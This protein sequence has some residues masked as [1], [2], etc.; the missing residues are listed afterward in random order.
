MP[1]VLESSLSEA[2]VVMASISSR[3]SSGST[4]P[5]GKT[6]APP[7]FA[8]EARSTRKTSTPSFASLTNKTVA[9]GCG[10]V[11]S[12]LGS[13]ICVFAPCNGFFINRPYFSQIIID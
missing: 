13:A 8:L 3:P 7:K 11:G 10:T 9:A 1:K 6:N 5:P 12:S 4:L 2:P